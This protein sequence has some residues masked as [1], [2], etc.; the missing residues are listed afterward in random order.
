MTETPETVAHRPPLRTALRI[1]GFKEPTTDSQYYIIV[2]QKVLC[3]VTAFPKAL[4]LWFASLN[5]ECC[6]QA[7]EVALFVQELVFGVPTSDKKWH[8]PLS[9]IQSYSATE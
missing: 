8:L 4:I 6:K 3:S 7:K 1:A 5:L 2:E 9:R